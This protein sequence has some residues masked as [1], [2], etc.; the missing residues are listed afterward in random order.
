MHKETHLERD[1]KCYRK[2][3]AKLDLPFME[4]PMLF[5]FVCKYATHRT[6]EDQMLLTNSITFA[7][8][9]VQAI[10]RKDM[11]VS[12]HIRVYVI[13]QYDIKGQGASK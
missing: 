3:K 1:L 10:Y 4:V 13:H 11:S 7:F 8:S 2:I 12:N 9:S 6:K 5:N